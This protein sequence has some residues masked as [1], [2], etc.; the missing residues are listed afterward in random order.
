MLPHRASSATISLR[1]AEA[2]KLIDKNDDGVLTRIEVI[3]ACRSDQRVREVLQ[4]PTNI[5]Q[6]DGSRDAFEAVFQKMDADDSK[7]VDLPEFMAFWKAHIVPFLWEEAN[8]HPSPHLKPMT[9]GACS[10][11]DRPPCPQR[12]DIP[13]TDEDE[14]DS[15]IPTAPA[16]V[17]AP[18]PAPASAP[19]PAPPPVPAPAVSVPAVPS[20]PTT[21]PAPSVSAPTA[22]P[23][24]A[25]PSPSTPRPLRPLRSL[26]VE[27]T[28]AEAAASAADPLPFMTATK[29]KSAA[30]LPSKDCG[31]SCVDQ[32]SGEAARLGTAAGAAAAGLATA[33]G[34]VRSAEATAAA[35]AAA[36]A[37]ALAA[38][39]TGEV[40]EQAASSAAQAAINAVRWAPTSQD[41]PGPVGCDVRPDVSARLEEILSRLEGTREG[42]LEGIT[43]RDT[44]TTAPTAC[45]PTGERGA[46]DAL[47]GRAAAFRARAQALH[48]PSSAMGVPGRPPWLPV[49]RPSARRRL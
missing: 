27:L 1:C 47:A 8:V 41:R 40:A 42:P 29:Q 31:S 36:V 38:G 25:A 17:P 45:P 18:A 10:N 21:A 12:F 19:A 2:F 28:T 20:V 11:G 24:R 30:A 23:T 3:Q 34:A 14:D 16:P 22:A 44:P 15:P 35:I 49:S 6:E 46:L 32:A 37:A 9:W 13:S 48:K 39:P 43:T 4:L 5:R 33:V 7:A 26:E